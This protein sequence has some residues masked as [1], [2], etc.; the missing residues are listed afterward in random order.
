MLKKTLV[1]ILLAF[2]AIGGCDGDGGRGCIPNEELIDSECLSEDLFDIC[3]PYFCEE[4]VVAIPP[5]DPSCHPLDCQTIFC[6]FMGFKE[7][8]VVEIDG[9]PALFGIFFDDLIN[10]PDIPFGPCGF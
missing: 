8:E 3:F 4:L 7:L 9:F 5:D 6:P 10:T 2:L 1:I